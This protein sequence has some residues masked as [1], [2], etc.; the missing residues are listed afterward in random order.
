MLYE[1][2]KWSQLYS[3]PASSSRLGLA[4]TAGYPG[5]KQQCGSHNACETYVKDEGK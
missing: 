1:E 3:Q 2:S 5:M 4:T